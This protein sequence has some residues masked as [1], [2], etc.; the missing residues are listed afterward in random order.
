M[1]K[2]L[3]FMC[4]FL[5]PAT[6]LLSQSLVE[7]SKKEQERR[8]KLKGKNV[9]VVTNDDLK[10]V[11]RAPAVSVPAPPPAEGEAAEPPGE[12]LTEAQPVEGSLETGGGSPFATG[13]LADV[14]MVESPEFALHPP[15]GRYAEISIMGSLELDVDVRNGPG[16]DLAIYARW[17]GARAEAPG[18]E[19]EGIPL[20]PWPGGLSS[21]GVLVWGARGEWE[22]IGRGT[23]ESRPETFDLG[24]NS[25]VTKIRIIFKPDNNASAPYNNYQ[26][27]MRP[28]TM[29]IDAVEALH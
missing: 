10:S 4:L 7:A 22:A 23:G 9:K 24:Q 15:D 26:L 1:K 12:E 5:L 16:D 8:E 2:T 18:S 19:G 25:H 21:Y 27:G 13:V 11:R 29:G 28:F 17:A 6:L 14:I 20:S 3:H